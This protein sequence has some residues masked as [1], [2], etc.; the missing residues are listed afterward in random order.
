MT[1]RSVPALRMPKPPLIRS[2]CCHFPAVLIVAGLNFMILCVM[3]G[4][5][6]LIL[7]VWVCVVAVWLVVGLVVGFARPSTRDAQIHK[8]H[9]LF[10]FAP[11]TPVA[12]DPPTVPWDQLPTIRHN[13]F[14]HST[15]TRRFNRT[16]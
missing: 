3:L 16:P 15:T 1:R 7:L 14:A 13:E 5:W 9:W 11:E 2:H 12:D 6:A 10:G 4:V 8:M